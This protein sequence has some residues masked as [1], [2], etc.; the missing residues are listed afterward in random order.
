M[1]SAIK[2]P[3]PQPWRDTKF[4]DLPIKVQLNIICDENTANTTHTVDI[5]T[6]QN[7]TSN[8]KAAKLCYNYTTSGLQQQQIMNHLMKN[9]P[10]KGEIGPFNNNYPYNGITLEFSKNVA[11][12]GKTYG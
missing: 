10:A 2:W 3:P 8:K 9:I 12:K 7:Q 4:D 1:L 6:E 11:Q 5:I